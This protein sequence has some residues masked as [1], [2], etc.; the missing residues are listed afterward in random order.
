MFPL[1]LKR[2]VELLAPRLAVVFRRLVRL[3]SFPV[4]WTVANVTPIP[5]GPPS[6]SASNYRQISFSLYPVWPHRQC[7]GLIVRR[8]HDRGSLSAVSLVICS[9]ASIAVCNT[10]S[11]GATA[12]CRVGG[13]DQ[14]IGS[15]VSDAI[16]LSW[17]WLTATRS[18]PLGY[19]SKL[20]QVVDN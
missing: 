2:T 14:S 13:C 16:V 6:S 4:C 17:L 10:R 12:L 1:F 11:S 5:K 20:L 19:L 9:P 8:W 3:G 15:T 18:S 7:F